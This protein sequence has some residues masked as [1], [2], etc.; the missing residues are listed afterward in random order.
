MTVL[1]ICKSKR[2]V[3]RDVNQELE[4]GKLGLGNQRKQKELEEDVPGAI[5][6]AIYFGRRWAYGIAII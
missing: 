6:V 5:R 4:L 1:M 2:V 3:I